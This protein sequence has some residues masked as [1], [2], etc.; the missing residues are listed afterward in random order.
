M[1]RQLK[2]GCFILILLFAPAPTVIAQTWFTVKW[3]TDGDTIVLSNGKRVRYIGINAP[4]I[5]HDN[6]RAQPF[7]VV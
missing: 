5:D 4:E 6:H 7:P 3:V 1:Y 2:A